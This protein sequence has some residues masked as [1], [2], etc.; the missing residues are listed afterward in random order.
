MFSRFVG[1]IF[2]ASCRILSVLG[3][4]IFIF[5]FDSSGMA[6]TDGKNKR[7]ENEHYRLQSR[8]LRKKLRPNFLHEDEFETET[9]K[10]LA[11]MT[12]SGGAMPKQKRKRGNDTWGFD[13][14][15]RCV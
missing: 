12:R 14:A 9:R 10:L 3:V 8:T 15:V 7:D 11:D 5:G 2:R 13:R 4:Q 6:G 1:F